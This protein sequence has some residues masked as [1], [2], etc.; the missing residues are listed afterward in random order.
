MQTENKPKKER[1]SKRSEKKWKKRIGTN[2]CCSTVAFQMHKY[3]QITC[4][5]VIKE[6]EEMFYYYYFL[7]LSTFF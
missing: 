5:V 1:D 7:F 2:C 6:N 3:T 4:T